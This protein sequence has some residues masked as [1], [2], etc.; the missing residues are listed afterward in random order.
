MST[1]V[2][3]EGYSLTMIK[4]II[5]YERDDSVAVPKSDGHVVTK[6]GQRCPRKSMQG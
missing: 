1:Q 4:A 2:D 6:H 3:S 5:N